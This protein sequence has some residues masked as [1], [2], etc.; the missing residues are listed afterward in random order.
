MPFAFIVILTLLF[1]ALKLTGV[2]A[3]SWVIVASPLI[4][5]AVVELVI[6]VV[7]VIKTMMEEFILHK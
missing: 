1:A 3:M 6:M 4:I 7:I 2:A 5:A